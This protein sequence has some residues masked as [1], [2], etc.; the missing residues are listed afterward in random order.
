MSTQLLIYETAVPVSAARHREHSV[1]SSGYGFSRHV[2]AV[3][4]MAV[5]FAAAAGEYAIVFTG[6][7]EVVMPA[8]IL[9]M[10]GQENAYLDGEGGWSAKYIPAF[11]RRYPFVFSSS[12]DGQTFTL[13]IDESFAGLNREGRGRALFGEDGK[14]TEYVQN[15]L[16]FVQEYQAQFQR[17]R[18]FCEKLRKLELLEPMQAS[19]SLDSGEH[20][21]LTGF[22]AVQRNKLKALSGE[23][24]AELAK[25]DELELM[26]LH[27]Q[28]MNNFNRVKERLVSAKGEEAA[29][30]SPGEEAEEP[31]EEVADTDA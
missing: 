7:E 16:K 9:G 14:P 21:S 5:E 22:Q 27:L 4:L 26:Y 28:S 18:A 24:L 12:N 13:C 19:V 2:N 6:N 20:L 31:S 15:V 3:P 10:R 30:E 8:V 25:S 1:E 11:I 29:P 17:T 23:S